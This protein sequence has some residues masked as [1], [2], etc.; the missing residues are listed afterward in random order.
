MTVQERLLQQQ[1]EQEEVEH[2]VQEQLLKAT[3]HAQAGP[4]QR[5]EL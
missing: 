1:Q 3:L 4:V 2:D 5:R